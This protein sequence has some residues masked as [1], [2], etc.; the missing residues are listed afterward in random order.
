MTWFC[1]CEPSQKAWQ[2][3]SPLA[4]RSRQFPTVTRRVYIVTYFKDRFQRNRKIKNGFFAVLIMT[5]VCHCE[6]AK[7]MHGNPFLFS[8]RSRPFPTVTQRVLL[9]YCRG[10]P[11]C[12]PVFYRKTAGA[13]IIRPFLVGRSFPLIR[14]FCGKPQKI[15]LPPREG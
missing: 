1:H 8:E 9:K 4:E 5:L 13:D 11:M 3:V 14:L 2:S 12:A 6:H 15:H 7:G 10:A